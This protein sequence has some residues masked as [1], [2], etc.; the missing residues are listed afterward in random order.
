M[1]LASFSTVSGVIFLSGETA[2]AVWRGPGGFGKKSYEVITSLNAE[3][4]SSRI[5]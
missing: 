2:L 4:I 5:M 1:S 3:Q